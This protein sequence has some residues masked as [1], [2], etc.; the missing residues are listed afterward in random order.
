MRILVENSGY[1][2][3][4]LG[5]VCMLQVAYGRLHAAFPRAE[6][7]IIT[8]NRRGLAR[9]CEGARAVSAEQNWAWRRA[10]DVY[11]RLRRATP[12]FGPA[13]RAHT[14]GAHD[15]LLRFRAR[16]SVSKRVVRR[17]DLF[18][19]SG[20]GFL[21]DV[22]RGQTWSV[23]ERLQASL[24]EGAPVAL[25]GQG[26]GPLRDP[27][28]LEKARAVLPGAVLIGLREKVTSL[29]V[30]ERLGVPRERVVVTGDDAVEPAYLARRE[31]MGEHLGVNLRVAEY[32]R[33]GREMI[34]AVREPLQ[35]AARRLKSGMLSV[36][37]SLSGDVES[38]SDLAVAD[39]LIGGPRA[40]GSGGEAPDD[41]RAIIDRVGRCRVVVTGSY[42][43][44]VFALGQGIPSVCLFNSEYYEVKFRGLAE[45][46]GE[47][48]QVLSLSDGRLREKLIEEILN[49]WERAE[50]W[51]PRLLRE[52]ERQVTAGRAAY[53]RLR[54][55]VGDGR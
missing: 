45:L 51:R 8:R 50:V 48:A 25:F 23:L 17:A 11:T 16:H 34:A 52:V 12:S 1:D 7:D 27:V 44:A 42:H 39:S 10:R 18:V 43:A 46:F 30:L 28:L 19:V 49:A 33:V 24:E 26:I 54:E 41:P 29:P 31:E 35:D 32:T 38:A 47:G 53:E 20:G 37:V 4:N 15:C 14:P 13:I 5:D 36:P 9:F 22:F 6:F 21:T 40:S 2:L 55:T 3:D